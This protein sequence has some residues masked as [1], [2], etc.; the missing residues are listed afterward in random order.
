MKQQ[1]RV[2]LERLENH[3]EYPGKVDE[4]RLL[5]T[6]PPI[7]DAY[8]DII[9]Q[10]LALL[11]NG[12]EDECIQL[13]HTEQENL[14]PVLERL[15]PLAQQL[16]DAEDAVSKLFVEYLYTRVRLVAELKMFPRFGAELLEQMSPKDSLEKTIYYLETTMT[17]KGGLYQQLMATLEAQ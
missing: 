6:L 14:T 2:A 8:E 9:Q 11:A 16:A 10:A 17:G 15:A 5:V 12:L 1:I 3:L 13:L 7:Q 4:Q